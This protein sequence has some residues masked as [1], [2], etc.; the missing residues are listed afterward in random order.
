MPSPYL[1][2]DDGTNWPHPD[3]PAE[4]QWG[5][6]YGGPRPRTEQMVAASYIAAYTELIRL[7]VRQRNARI[8]AIRAAIATK[9]TPPEPQP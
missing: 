6:R 1:R 7:P 9:P 8:R 3:D 5:L 2:L 4:I